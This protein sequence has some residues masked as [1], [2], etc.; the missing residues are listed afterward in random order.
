MMLKTYLREIYI[1]RNAQISSGPVHQFD[2][3]LHVEPKPLSISANITMLDFDQRITAF[4]TPILLWQEWP[5]KE[6][7]TKL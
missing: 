3:W 2:K 7:K 5:K 6:N 4:N 1:Q